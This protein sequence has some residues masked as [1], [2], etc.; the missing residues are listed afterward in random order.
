MFTTVRTPAGAFIGLLATMVILTA[1]A[2]TSG[3]G[4]GMHAGFEREY[5]RAR[6]ALEKSNYPAAI[7]QF[8]A[9]VEKSG[10]LESRIRLELAHALLRADR[11]EEASQQARLV[12]SAH[13]DARRSAALAVY[14]TA[15]HRLAQMAMSG[16]DF[17]PATATHLANAKKALDEMLEKSPDMDPSGSMHTRRDMAAASLARL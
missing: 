9:L 3:A 15:E 12:A 17:G 4:G 11:Y 8:S 10:P 6:G 1:C 16:G 7:R 13:E 14:G 2:E 5:S